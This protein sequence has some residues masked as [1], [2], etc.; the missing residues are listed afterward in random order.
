MAATV[1]PLLNGN[2]PVVR[3]LNEALEYEKI[4]KLRDEVFAGSHPR[5]T[6]PAHAVQNSSAQ[7]QSQ[8]LSQSYLNIPPTYPPS[9]S[10]PHPANL[11]SK[12]EEEATRS[13]KQPN[14]GFTT[15]TQPA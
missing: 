4:L 5:L 9:A 6:V 7:S 3:H 11:Q 15:S 14:G 1:G 8:S 2:M 12:R 13:Q 10:Q